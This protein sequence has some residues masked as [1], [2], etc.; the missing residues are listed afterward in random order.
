MLFTFA[1]RQQRNTRSHRR[2]LA[3]GAGQSVVRRA[4]A[5]HKAETLLRALPGA[6]QNS[7]QAAGP[8]GWRQA[9]S[10]AA[11]GD[12]AGAGQAAG[13]DTGICVEIR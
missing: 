7:A 8:I 12:T 10:D 6:G 4:A 5:G 9:E 2:S 1:G 13:R 11:P 3:R